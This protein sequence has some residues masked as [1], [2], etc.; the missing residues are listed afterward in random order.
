MMY[1][2][3]IFNLLARPTNDTLLKI[4]VVTLRIHI[5]CTPAFLLSKWLPN[6]TLVKLEIIP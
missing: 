6:S 2:Q 4:R 1:Y 3:V 5:A